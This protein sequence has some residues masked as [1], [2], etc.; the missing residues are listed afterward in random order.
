METTSDIVRKLACEA[1]FDLV[2]IAEAKPLDKESANL[3]D[4][5][6]RGYHATMNWMER[7]PQKRTDPSIVLDGARSVISLAKNYYTEAE[8]DETSAKISRYAWGD[9]YHVV[10]GG[11][12]K[13]LVELLSSEFPGKKFLYYCD[14]GPV[15]DKAWAQRAGIGWIGKHT[16]VINMEIGSWIFLSEIITDLECAVDA[17]AV[18]HCG[19]CR[20]CID[21]CPTGAIV[22]P[23][24]LDSNKCISFLTIE[25]RADSI[26]S[27]FLPK[28]GNW[29][30]GCDICQDVCP[31]NI[32]F[33]TPTDEPPFSPRERNLN[34]KAQD[35]HLMTREEFADWFRRSP[36]KRARYDGLRRNANALTL[37]AE[38]GEE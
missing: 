5:L 17:E 30:F 37:A 3:R 27:Q 35:I 29:V 26:P 15:M 33:Q 4:W 25:N 31:W 22:E 38:S 14:T 10:V 6:S 23:Y 16:N 7:N 18:D 12:L 2:G 24:V 11:M 9:D 1:G 8:H 20:R 13:R 32:R 28:L 34:L 36:V 21:A 19:S